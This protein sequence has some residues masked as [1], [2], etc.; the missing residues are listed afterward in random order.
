MRSF[1]STIIVNAEILVGL[2][3]WEQEMLA[4]IVAPITVG[5]PTCVVVGR[6]PH[7]RVL[8]ALAVCELDERIPACR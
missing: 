2:E 7:C 4:A 1:I 8:V 5:L 3:G 6:L